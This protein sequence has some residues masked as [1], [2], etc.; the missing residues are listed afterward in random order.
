MLALKEIMDRIICMKVDVDTYLG[1]RDCV[2]R[3]LRTF[4]SYGIKASFFVP[5]GPDHTGRAIRRFFKRRGF[6]KKV[7]RTSVI[8]N[9]GIRTVLYGLILPGP[10]ILKGNI[11]TAYRILREGHELGMHGHDHVFWHDKVLK[12][13]YERTR[14]EIIKSI[15]TYTSVLGKKPS[16]FAAP[17]W[18]INIHAY[19]ILKQESFLYS[20]STRGYEPF[21]PVFDGELIEILEIPTTLPTLDEIL[22]EKGSDPKSLAKSI[23]SLLGPGLNVFTI[24]A[25]LEGKNYEDFL[26]FFLDLALSSGYTFINLRDLSSSLSPINVKGKRINY[27]QVEGRA[28]LVT[29]AE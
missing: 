5:T 27:G 10:E 14:K 13:D 1:M 18:I 7:R 24:H 9:Y 21:Y 19:R 6:I 2:P 15:S 3:L 25:E 4:S 29:I 11:D 12:L 22:G 16:S 26:K 20:S 23:F 8:K 28:G 17:G